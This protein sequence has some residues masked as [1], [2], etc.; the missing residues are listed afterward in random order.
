MGQGCSCGG[1][2]LPPGPTT[3]T[4]TEFV[5]PLSGA[6]GTPFALELPG[7]PREQLDFDAD[8]KEIVPRALPIT[9]AS[10]AVARRWNGGPGRGPVGDCWQTWYTRGREIGR[11]ISASVSEAEARTPNHALSPM[12]GGQWWSCS[13]S[14][15]AACCGSSEPRHPPP[16]DNVVTDMQAPTSRCEASS[17][18]SPKKTGDGK[19]KVAL[20]CFKKPGTRAFKVERAALVS[21][22]VHPHVV[23]LLESYEDC[24]GEDVLVLEL[25]DHLTV[26]EL[27]VSAREQGEFLSEIL[28]VRLVRQVLLAL[29]HIHACGVAH[30]DVKPENMLLH[31]LSLA[32]HRVELKLGDFGWALEERMG[33]MDGQVPACSPRKPELAGSL[34]YAPPEL[35][36]M[37]V[38][39]AGKPIPVDQ[40]PSRGGPYDAGRSDL[41]SLGV[42]TYLLLVGHNPFVAANKQSDPKAVENEVIRLVAMGK[43]DICSPRWL[44]LSS[45]ARDFISTFLKV[46]AGARPTAT[47][48]LR[49]PF[50]SKLPEA[51]AEPASC[52]LARGS[53]WSDLDGFQQLA[54]VAVA[55]AITEPELVPEVVHAAERA[56][57]DGGSLGSGYL[58]ELARELSSLPCW[59][60]LHR[61]CIWPEVVRLAFRYLDVNGDGVLC[62]A[63]VSSHLVPFALGDARTAAQY[64]VTQWSSG[65]LD[66]VE[67]LELRDLCAALLASAR[68][69][70]DETNDSLGMWEHGETSKSDS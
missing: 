62:P 5:R 42:V 58:W 57:R 51:H 54:W 68:K 28:V 64:W 18:S 37:P 20:K 59:S 43:Y 49:H 13:G 16:L 67:G 45:E 39:I 11:G 55:R 44:G 30:R 19:R 7:G 52:W 25:C 70:T 8:V 41:W 46:A 40:L 4:D 12:S 17:S 69:D 23:R 48:A 21:V 14:S 22:G 31:S 60:W 9:A 56:S 2:K 1:A 33:G 65:L 35:N 24:D 27:H 32:E 38:D 34:W 66:G 36:P 26:F 15:K 61:R 50:I 63:D 6:P 29:E 3:A 47:E 10:F 53:C